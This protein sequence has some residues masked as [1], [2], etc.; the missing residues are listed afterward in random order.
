MQVRP[1]SRVAAWLI[2][3][4]VAAFFCRHSVGAEDVKIQSIPRPSLSV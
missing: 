1:I 3:F 4:S 2:I